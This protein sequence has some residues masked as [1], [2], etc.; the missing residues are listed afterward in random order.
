MRFKRDDVVMQECPIP[1]SSSGLLRVELLNS[2]NSCRS[3]AQE[4]SS[5]NYR[6]GE[7][8]ALRLLTL[9]TV[10]VESRTKS[11]GERGISKSHAQRG[12]GSLCCS[13]SL[14]AKG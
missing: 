12:L 13:I 4:R 1:T 2:G 9:R 5:R 11:I 3:C 14:K 7:A 8:S 6:N 10:E